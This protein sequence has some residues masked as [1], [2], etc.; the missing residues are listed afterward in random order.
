M[1]PITI[2][3]GLFAF[4]GVL[5]NVIVIVAFL[6]GH[7]YKKSN[8]RVYV[9]CLG[10]NDLLASAFLIP[11]EIIKQRNYFRFTSTATCKAKCFFY[12]W[13]TLAGALCLLVVCVDRYRK[14]LSSF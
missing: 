2:V 6:R 13:A 11:L 10:I 12:V 3:F 5:G 4:V 7:V 1:L 14:K 8:F 9:M